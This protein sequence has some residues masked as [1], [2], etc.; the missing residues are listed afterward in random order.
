VLKSQS[1]VS[2]DRKA[3]VTA[4]EVTK[5]FF[6]APD[7]LSQ[8]VHCVNLAG[9]M[10]KSPELEQRVSPTPKPCHQNKVGLSKSASRKGK[11]SSKFG[12]SVEYEKNADIE[13]E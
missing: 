4:A 10:R 8:S 6:K 5:N 9:K 11:L 2:H 13:E 12:R 1:T 3:S 7:E